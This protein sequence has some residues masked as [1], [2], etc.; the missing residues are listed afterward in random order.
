[1]TFKG[2]FLE[3]GH[4][5]ND[6]KQVVIFSEIQILDQLILFINNA[7]TYNFTELKMSHL[8]DDQKYKWCKTESLYCQ[9]EEY[10]KL[11]LL[12]GNSLP[13]VHYKLALNTFHLLIQNIKQYVISISTDYNTVHKQLHCKLLMNRVL[14][15]LFSFKFKC[16]R[17]RFDDD[18][19]GNNN[20]EISLFCCDDLIST[21]SVFKQLVC[22]YYNHKNGIPKDNMQDMAK[23]FQNEYHLN[24]HKYNVL[25]LTELNLTNKLDFEKGYAKVLMA[26]YRYIYGYNHMNNDIIINE[27]C[28]ITICLLL[29]NNNK[30]DEV[31]LGLYISNIGEYYG[32][33]RS[34]KPFLC[35]YC[36]K[37]MST[38]RGLR[39]H[40]KDSHEN[41]QKTN[42][43]SGIHYIA[44]IM[45][46]Q[47]FTLIFKINYKPNVNTHWIPDNI[48]KKYTNQLHILSQNFNFHDNKIKL[49]KMNKLERLEFIINDINN[50]LSTQNDSENG[51]NT[52]DIMEINDTDSSTSIISSIS[53]SKSEDKIEFDL[54][55][56]TTK[57]AMMTAH[58]IARKFHAYFKRY[59]Y[60]HEA[61]ENY[62]FILDHIYIVGGAIRNYLIDQN[63]QD[64][65]IVIDT[66]KLQQ[67]QNQH[68]IH[69]H[70]CKNIEYNINEKHSENKS[71]YN[72]D[73]MENNIPSISLDDDY[74][75]DK[76][77]IKYKKWICD[78]K[79]NCKC[80][81]HLQYYKKILSQYQKH[82]TPENSGDWMFNA[83]TLSR[84]LLNE[85][86]KDFSGNLCMSV[87]VD[88]NKVIKFMIKSHVLI[89]GVDIHQQGIDIADTTNHQFT[90]GSG[91]KLKKLSLNE[92]IQKYPYKLNYNNNYFHYLHLEK[93]WIQKL[94]YG[95]IQESNYHECSLKNDI[96]NRDFTINAL[97]LP[98]SKI[99]MTKQC[100]KWHKR[101]IIDLV[102]GIDDIEHKIFRVPLMSSVKHILLSSPIRLLRVIK[103]FLILND[104]KNDFSID[105]KLKHGIIEYGYLLKDMSYTAIQQVFMPLVQT[106]SN[107]VR[108]TKELLC[109]LRKY[110]LEEILSG[111][112]LSD[113]G[114][115]KHFLNVVSKFKEEVQCVYIE[116]K[117]PSIFSVN[118]ADLSKALK[119]RKY[120]MLEHKC[121]YY[122]LILSVRMIDQ[123]LVQFGA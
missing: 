91:G 9:L 43:F 28:G 88:K 110:H 104:E 27:I 30:F 101:D 107:D 120:Q 4:R 115:C 85:I 36:N 26:N 56:L 62:M 87:F 83:K 61:N 111:I 86:K 123:L 69:Y 92:Y 33:F 121:S 79:E 57:R 98:L 93:R 40:L 96:I 12:H 64:L 45:L 11:L 67:L 68:L 19:K 54:L 55:S 65:D 51:E 39:A 60:C 116:H 52:N 5:R 106:Y 77:S 63:V 112:I 76:D 72:G 21:Q 16:N 58:Y 89:N 31:L 78:K 118:E 35:F 23:Y 10:A 80:L 119:N 3:F 84:I 50:I 82:N 94:K 24:L 13:T 44:Y 59:H 42:T 49:Q 114:F 7:I 15:V 113:E 70:E 22:S 48:L 8:S 38:G 109:M 105:N 20:D 90:S 37:L 14:C 74:G 103:Y 53:S 117:Y 25:Y 6:M 2:E 32:Y 81:W 66:L 29:E 97:M 102:N 41:K 108:K 46:T 34:H 73:N 18:W 17:Y 95:T 1:M 71:D 75:L 99:L 122:N 47:L 100:F